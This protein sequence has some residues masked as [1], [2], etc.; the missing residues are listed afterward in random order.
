MTRAIVRGQVAALADGH[1]GVYR[2]EALAIAQ[3][4]AQQ[5]LLRA[6]DAECGPVCP[7]GVE[8]GLGE[9]YI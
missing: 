1:E 5:D 9:R 6:G 4:L 2:L 8:L 7:E 3:D